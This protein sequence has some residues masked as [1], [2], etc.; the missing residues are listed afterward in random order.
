MS[1]ISLARRQWRTQKV[2]SKPLAFN[3]SSDFIDDNLL[4]TGASTNYANVPL[5]RAQ[6]VH[7]LIHKYDS[8]KDHFYEDRS[9][10]NS[11]VHGE[12][13]PV[14]RNSL[15]LRYGGIRIGYRG[16]PITPSKSRIKPIDIRRINASWQAL[17]RLP[18]LDLRTK[19]CL[20]RKQR[21]EVLFALRVAG[22][23]RRYSPGRGGSYNRSTNSQYGC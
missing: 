18:K 11:L 15:K 23:G 6:D 16:A 17:N 13:P 1:S 12:T 10:L 5:P 20:S 8:V 14:R 4:S 9:L 3:D 22:R 2:A 19:T 7:R 21:K